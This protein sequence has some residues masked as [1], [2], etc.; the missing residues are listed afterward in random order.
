VYE[1]EVLRMETLV[2]CVRM[3]AREAHINFSNFPLAIKFKAIFRVENGGGGLQTN[4]GINYNYP[5][6][7]C[8]VKFKM[9]L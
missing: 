9:R 1:S 4:E 7:L 5:I 6:S 3:S 2:G 8:V